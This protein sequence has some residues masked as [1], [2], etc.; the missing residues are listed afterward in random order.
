MSDETRAGE[1]AEQATTPEKIRKGSAR[2]ERGNRTGFT[3]GACSAA[4]AR[5]ATLG[6]LLS[7]VP[8]TVICRLPN[9]QEQAFVV[10]DGCVEESSG[11]AH[12][13]IVKDA[14]DD[15][16]ATH[17][18]HMTADVRLL[19]HRAGEIVLKGGFGVGV[20]TKD[21]LGL[22]VGGPAINPVPRRN[23]LDN[24]RAVAGEL[25]DH[26]GLEV[27]ISVPGGDEMAKKTLNARLGILGGIS[28]LGTTG[29][30]RPY[31]T[32]AFRA[33]V[34]QAVDV[35]AKQGQ[36][37]VVF[38]TG[39]RTEK[40]A[41]RQLP[42]LDESC[43][44]QMGDFVKAAFSSAIKHK[45]PTVY[46]GAMVGKLTKMCQG[47]AVT[48]AW[49]AE[50]DRDILADSAREVGAPDDLVEEIRAAET[51][52]FAAERLANL[53]LAVAFHRQ[54]AIKAIRSLKGQY[55]GEYRLAVL[56]CDFEG[57]FICRVNEDEA[58]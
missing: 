45:L 15:P 3:T 14:G 47:L 7:E 49:K 1:A 39:G 37:S 54:L 2:R 31:S 34:V 6:L 30:V 52:R 50:V 28:I 24:V 41:M 11:L 51:A 35:A 44:V 33:S 29:I 25:L 32:A 22:E 46:V 20:V 18:A 17:G 5:A 40:F 23:I 38:T 16:D 53:G 48:H 21:G 26:D 58:L 42:D 56:V 55:P 43:F 36:T 10:T 19:P 4:A 8:D 9:G 27:T 57:Q 13:V 12:A